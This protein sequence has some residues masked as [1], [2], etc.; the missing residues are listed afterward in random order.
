[1]TRGEQCFNMFQS[2]KSLK[3]QKHTK[4]QFWKLNFWLYAISWPNISRKD[5][6][7]NSNNNKKYLTY[8]TVKIT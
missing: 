5:I 7:S 4:K 3:L 8:P 1:M 6:L 2:R